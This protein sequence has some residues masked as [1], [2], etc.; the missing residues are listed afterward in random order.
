MKR[1]V[2]LARDIL[3]QVEGF[4]FDGKPRD[5]KFEG[6]PREEISY[7]VMLLEEAGL[8]KAANHSSMD[9][10]EYIPIRLTHAGHEFIEAARQDTLWKEAKDAT[11]RSTGTLTI[12]GL[13]ITL[14]ALIQHAAKVIFK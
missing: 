7:H 11:L 14:A 4:P 6:H 9:G 5:V 12:E 1:D 8:L 13:K 10:I 2:D 3:A